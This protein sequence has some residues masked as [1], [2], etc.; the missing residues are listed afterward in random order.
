MVITVSILDRFAKH[1]FATVK[2]DKFPTKLILVYPP[3]LKYVAALPWESP[4]PFAQ[5]YAWRHY[6][7]CNCP[8]E[9]ASPDMCPCKWWTF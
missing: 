2:T 1:S 3:H 9:K 8:A 4:K 6:R 7:H 5:T